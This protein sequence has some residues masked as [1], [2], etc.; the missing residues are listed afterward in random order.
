MTHFPV[1][2]AFGERILTLVVRDPEL[3]ESMLG[4]LR[5]EGARLVSR[6]GAAKAAQWHRRQSLGIAVRYGMMRILRRKPPVRWITTADLEPQGPWWTGMARDVRYAW[7]ATLQRPMLSAAV[8][9]TL[10]LA[11]AANSTTFS[12][13]DALVLRPYRFA[14]V[15]R[16]V[17]ATTV[18]PENPFLD[19]I[20]VTA[21]DFRE[22]REQS[23]TVKGWAMYQWW[24]ANLSGVD[25]PEQVPGFFV[26]P[27][28]FALLSAPPVMGREFLE[29]EGQRGQHHRVVIG[30][31]LWARRFAS[32]PA[33]IGRSI[34][35]DGEPYEV[36]GVA[37]PGFNTPDGAEVWA[38]IALTDEQWANRR[39][40]N[41]GVM[42]RLADGVALE[43]ARAELGAIVDTQRREH[44]DTNLKRY[45]RVLSFTSG[46]ADPGAG[47]FIS[48][49]QAAAL[50]LLLIACANVANLLMARGA[51]RASEY[52]IRLALGSSRAR[53]FGQ[54]LIEGLVLAMGAVLLSM[55]LIVAGLALS[56][57]S[58]PASVLRFIPG[59][60][61][62]RLDLG[63]FA[64][65]A[66][67]GTLAMIFFSVLPAIQATKS[68]VA[69][70]LRQSGRS[71]TPGRN[72]QWARS[73]LATTQMALALALVFASALAMTA[74]YETVNGRLG[75]DKNNVLVA[76]LNLPERNYSDADTRRRF[77]T[78]VSDAMRVI[79]AVAEVGAVSI[80]PAAFNNWSRRF[81]PE[82]QDI[83]ELEARTAQFRM[84][85]PEYFAAMKIPLIRGRMFDNSD[86]PGSTP[87]AILSTTLAVRYW[88]D[89]DP[90]GKRF[91]LAL[92][93]P[94]ITVVGVSG[95]IVHNWFDRRA[96]MVYVPV[97]QQAP[98]SVAFAVRAVGDPHALAGDLRRAVA[99]V[100]ADQPIAALES[101][102][103]MVEER[104][105]GFVFI[106]RAL[107]VV[108][109]IALVLSV[110]GIYSL[111]AFLNTQRT[112]EI[113]VR[114]ALGAGRWQVVRAMTGRAVGITIVGTVIGSALAIGAG[115][116]MESVLFG[117]VSTSFVQL[118]ALVVILG[119][120]AL[121]ASYVPARRAA[122]IDP[123][124][125]LRQP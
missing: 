111:M 85:T 119:S 54:T 32:D 18:A 108:G 71:L 82:G 81:F 55:P 17:V 110:I 29:S 10:A 38:P 63:L 48:V 52:S 22:W 7:R 51:E 33:V 15:D 96:D 83:P 98:Y 26:S 113:G 101:L 39:A 93:G 97:T 28:Y 56:K 73:A 19:R 104:A 91:R 95:D 47:S 59:W 72:R 94:W 75:F 68:Q 40:E 12:L 60:A 4:D 21:A 14:G 1:A 107:G 61:F 64:A 79:P 89:E 11:L 99:A 84:A 35:L 44:P 88:G 20:N 124:A 45:A 65:T 125:A 116:A 103:K 76:Q 34:R 27:G 90:L 69:D 77:I 9:F 13:M 49:W 123:M 66:A 80:I 102:D 67:L 114:M 106:S 78:E 50:L 117:L 16:L 53:L 57:A 24:D 58:I 23:K 70:T 118:G 31:G 46:M 86:R 5:E 74:A 122:R 100:D 120:V 6:A 25:V 109:L 62:I 92:D 36:V 8:V 3:R 87:V 2:T 105:A 43:Q 121:V 41:Y 112:Q 42:G 30:H 115:R 37:P